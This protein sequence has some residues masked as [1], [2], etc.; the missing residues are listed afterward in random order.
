MSRSPARWRLLYGICSDRPLGMVVAIVALSTLIAACSGGSK[1]A[2]SQP[3]AERSAASPPPN[4]QLKLLG[5]ATPS[6]E[7]R[8]ADVDLRIRHLLNVANDVYA[9]SGV[10]LT[11]DLVHLELVDYP[12]GNSTEAALEDL[13]YGAGP[14]SSVA[15]LRD[16][17]QADLVVLFTTY[18]NDG[19]CGF[20][21][22][23]GFGT[24][25]DFSRPAE[26][27]FG[28]SVVAANCADTTLAHEV[29]H[30]LGLAHSIDENPEGGSFHYGR[31]YVSANG[32]ATLMASENGF[33]SVAIPLFSSP[34]RRCEGAPCGVDHRR[35][36]GADAV[37]ALI[38][39]KDQVAAYR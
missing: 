31:G 5:L 7:R 1:S 22:V 14:L 12:D 13:T 9:E 39:A 6:I 27:D 32:F 19:F 37:R 34:D 21:W 35:V 2:S 11:L 4:T 10:A 26:A 8:Y 24:N 17:V 20:A 33:T 3:A 23:G 29:G 36:D 28:Y 25:G 30:N 15:A 18:A 16:A 38:A